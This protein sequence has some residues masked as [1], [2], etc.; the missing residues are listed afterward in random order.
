M[1]VKVSIERYGRREYR[2]INVD[3]EEAVR[4]ELESTVFSCA[5]YDDNALDTVEIE[6]NETARMFVLEYL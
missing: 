1:K 6:H 5:G 3:L 4:R 2:E